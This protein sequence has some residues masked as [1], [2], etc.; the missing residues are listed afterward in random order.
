MSLEVASSAADGNDDS[1]SIQ[2]K[3]GFDCVEK[4]LGRLIW[5]FSGEVVENFQHFVNLILSKV[6]IVV[7]R[8]FE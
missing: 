8:S 2:H 5:L 4:K 7:K 1:E 6:N 3:Q